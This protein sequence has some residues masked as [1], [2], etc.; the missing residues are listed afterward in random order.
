MLRPL[1]Y[2]SYHSGKWHVDGQPLKNGFDH[3]YVVNDHN[4]YFNPQN[5]TED[6]KPLPAVKPDSG[7]YLTVAIADHAIRCLEEHSEKHTARP[8]FHFVAFT[9][10]HFP[11]HALP[12]DIARYRGKFHEGWDVLRQKR[13]QRMKELGIVTCDLSARTPGVKAWNDLT[14]DEK[15]KN[16]MRMTIHA[17]MVDR[18]DREI[19]RVLEQVK[20]MGAMDD[21]LILFASD[22]GASAESLVRGDGHDPTAPPG[23]AKTF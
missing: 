6:D 18:M 10:P 2:R 11:L 22:N 21:T 12:E 7:F 3:S 16:E 1:G 19:G 5:H 14:A 20:A 8:F 23:S 15:E 17:A 9:S 4:R 13:H